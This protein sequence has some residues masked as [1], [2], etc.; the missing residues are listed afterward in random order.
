MLSFVRPMTLAI[1]IASASAQTTTPQPTPITLSLLGIG[2]GDANGGVSLTGAGTME[3][4]GPIQVTMTGQASFGRLLVTFTGKL[5]NFFTFYAI[6]TATSSASGISGS[7]IIS[8]APY[9]YTKGSFN[10]SITPSFSPTS[11]NVQFTL[12]GSGSMTFQPA[13]YDP[14]N[15]TVSTWATAGYPVSAPGASGYPLIAGGGGSPAFCVAGLPPNEGCSGFLLN[16]SNGSVSDAVVFSGSASGSNA[17][18]FQSPAN[19]APSALPGFTF[20]GY[21]NGGAAF[22]FNGPSAGAVTVD[23][24]IPLQPMEASYSAAVSCAGGPSPCWISMPATFAGGTI[25]TS[26]MTA[27]PVTVNPQGLTPG[28]YQANIAILI[29]AGGK[30][31]TVNVPVTALVTSPGPA[32][33]L[34][35]GGLQF[36]G[37][38]TSGWLQQFIT[39]SNSGPGSLNFSA[40]ASTLSGGNWLYVWP[41]SGTAAQSASG[42]VVNIQANPAG[43]N[44]GLYYGSVAFTAAGALNSPQSVEVVLDILPTAPPAPVAVPLATPASLL[45]VAPHSGAPPTQTALF[46]N[47]AAPSVD[48]E[49]KLTFE[50]GNGWF[51]D[52]DWY[53]NVSQ[54]NCNDDGAAVPCPLSSASEVFT[55]NP[56]GLTP[57]LFVGTFVPEFEKVKEFVPVPVILV[58]PPVPCYA[59]RLLPAFTNLVS[60][61]Q[62]EA[63]IPIPVQVQVLDD[64]GSPM[65]SGS[66]VAYSPGSQDPQVSLV[67]L[68]NGQW[69]G[70][71]MPHNVA[72]GPANIGVIA[73]SFSTPLYGRPGQPLYGSAGLEGTLAS[74]TGPVV[75]PGGVLSAASLA[76]GQPLAPGSYISIFGSNLAAKAE[77][78]SSLPLQTALAG[79]EVLLGDQPL[80][81]AYAGPT[82][83]NA[84]MPYGTVVNTLQNLTIVNNGASSLPEAVL[85]AEA[86]PAVFTQDQSGKGAGVIVVAQPSGARFLNTPAAPATA[87]DALVIYCSGLGAVN[88]PV[89]DGSAAP[90]SPL[91]NTANPVTATIGEKPAPVFFAGLAP[92]FAGLYQV[93]VTVPQGIASGSSVPVVLTVAGASSAPVTV[94][95]Q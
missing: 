29:N 72:G 82:Q 25:A 13:F 68:G 67:S 16:Q 34:S 11:Q 30:A 51:T 32:L 78:A 17:M 27:F 10:F 22:V 18:V 50:V 35:Q 6:G 76:T 81:L 47:L 45:F 49:S 70:S 86:Q 85:I 1:L 26:S 83:I 7:A 94:A 48:F 95:I 12:S 93:N 8:T 15:S 23:V 79:T 87:G 9:A 37:T 44:P 56:A 38:S 65:T 61:F 91:S 39:V 60:G 33:A 5:P 3:P 21:S 2:S 40:A 42:Q 36:Q 20:N 52:S 53:F 46:Y 43:L 54:I 84:V 74:N 90:S 28:V 58:V 75:T 24:A 31:S 73:T 57:G 88:P 62:S 14:Y 64:C 77:A 89:P 80:L 41:Q 59:S 55:V 69:T 71:W 19:A 63:G 92:G 66:V 4:Y